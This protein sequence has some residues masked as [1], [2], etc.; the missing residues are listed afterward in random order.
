MTK[1][2]LY[3]AKIG[4]SVMDNE[5]QVLVVSEFNA[6]EVTL[7]DSSGERYFAHPLYPVELIPDE[8]SI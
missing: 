3:N 7:I 5:G 4:Q 6:G 1:T 2:P 8:T